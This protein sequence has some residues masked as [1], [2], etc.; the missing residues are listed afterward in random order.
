MSILSIL[1]VIVLVG[2]LLWAVNSFIPMD[3]KVKSILNVVVVVLLIIWL[4]QAF[5]VL[6]GL[7]GIRVG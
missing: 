1:L 4:L 6:N 3:S 7:A 5:G 2:V